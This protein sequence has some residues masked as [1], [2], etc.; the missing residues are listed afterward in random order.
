VAQ[1]EPELLWLPEAQKLADRE[2]QPEAVELAVPQ[3]E[4]LLLLLL[5][6]EALEAPE[7]LA[8]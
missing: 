1:P 5:P 8:V 4:A 3:G 6:G 2:E 7:L